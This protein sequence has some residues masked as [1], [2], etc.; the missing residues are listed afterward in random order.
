MLN[1]MPVGSP[2]IVNGPGLRH[3]DINNLFGYLNVNIEAPMDFKI[4]F[5][6][7]LNDLGLIVPTGS[8]NGLYLSA[9]LKFAI[10]LGYKVKVI[11]EC[12][13]LDSGNVFNNFVKGAQ[14]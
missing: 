11:G 12:Y 14:P 5:L 6:P 10:S 4:P 9:L 13:E 1:P 3:I 8:W 7:V 2:I